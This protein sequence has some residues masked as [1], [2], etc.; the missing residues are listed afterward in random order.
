MTPSSN[1]E[2]TGLATGERPATQSRQKNSI[3]EMGQM[4]EYAG[5]GFLQMQ[6]GLP[7]LT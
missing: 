6:S 5:M 1:R 4:N 3:S 2:E 7:T